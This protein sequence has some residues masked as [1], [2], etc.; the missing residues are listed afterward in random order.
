MSVDKAIEIYVD[1]TS[2][3]FSAKQIG[4][5]GKFSTKTLEDTI[6]NIMVNVTNDSEER[7][8]DRRP[9]AC[10]V[11]V[12]FSITSLQALNLVEP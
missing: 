4:R 10:K 8:W 1:F 9:N 5:D 11:Y 6:R 2:K 12:Y 3:V 7:L